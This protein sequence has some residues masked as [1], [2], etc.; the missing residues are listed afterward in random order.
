MFTA[1]TYFHLCTPDGRVNVTQ[2]CK[3]MRYTSMEAL[4]K[5]LDIVH[6]YNVG[7]YILWSDTPD[8]LKTDNPEQ[9]PFCYVADTYYHPDNGQRAVALWYVDAARVKREIAP[10]KILYY[11]SRF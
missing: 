7:S 4:E 10:D 2:V 5:A 8:I 6:F 9:V 11:F 1:T 3:N